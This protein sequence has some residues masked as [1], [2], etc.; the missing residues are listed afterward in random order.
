[1][2]ASFKSLA[3]IAVAAKTRVVA[4]DGGCLPYSI[5]CN[6]VKLVQEAWRNPHNDCCNLPWTRWYDRAFA[7]TIQEAFQWVCRAAGN[8]DAIRVNRSTSHLPL[9]ADRSWRKQCQGSTYNFLVALHLRDPRQR[10]REKLKRWKLPMIG[11]SAIR[12]TPAWRASRAHWLLSRL[13]SMVPPRVQAAVFGAIWNRWTTASRFQ[14]SRCC[15]LCGL[16]RSDKLQHYSGC[17]VVRQILARKLR[18]PGSEFANLASFL[19]VNPNINSTG[20]LTLIALLV[21][22]VYIVTNKQRQ[23]GRPLGEAAFEAIAQA[24][25]QGARG[26]SGATRTLDWRWHNPSPDTSAIPAAPLLPYSA[27]TTRWRT[28]AANSNKKRTATQV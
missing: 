15:L 25:R 24:I 4:F 21:Y 26:H 7:K 13:A 19:L 10:M 12:N 28:L 8:L 6:D 2:H 27:S 17:S 5:F 1:M 22:A 23:I 11:T 3:W 20:V 9:N 18:L 14:S 16:E